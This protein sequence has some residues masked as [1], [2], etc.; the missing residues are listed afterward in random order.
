MRLEAQV[1]RNESLAPLVACR[2]EIKSQI[3]NKKNSI[4]KIEKVLE[5][6]CILSA[7]EIEELLN[8]NR[9]N[10]G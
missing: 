4:I 3:N 8:T 1:F 7:T 10:E 9:N 2:N 6:S 5:N